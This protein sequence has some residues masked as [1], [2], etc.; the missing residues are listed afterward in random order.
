MSAR[1]LHAKKVDGGCQQVGFARSCRHDNKVIGVKEESVKLS[2]HSL[3][4]LLWVSTRGSVLL[5]YNM[6]L[7]CVDAMQF[8]EDFFALCELAKA[9]SVKLIP[10]LWSFEAL[11]SQPNAVGRTQTQANH[12]YLFEAAAGSSSAGCCDAFVTLALTP[13]VSE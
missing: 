13:L 1:Q 5:L 8:K 2:R 9:A 12:K 10:V 6:F 7:H 3:G 11:D 4:A